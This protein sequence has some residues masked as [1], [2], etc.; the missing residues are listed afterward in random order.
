VNNQGLAYFLIQMQSIWTSPF[1]MLAT[2]SFLSAL[3]VNKPQV[4][5]AAQHFSGFIPLFLN[6]AQM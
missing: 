3:L 6:T 5:S 4:N 1:A 2:T